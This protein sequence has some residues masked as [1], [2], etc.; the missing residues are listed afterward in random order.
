MRM[1]CA[2]DGSEYSQWAVQA[3][4]AFAS[5]EPESVTLLHVIDAP[6]IA[7]AQGTNLVSANRA[8]KASE[9][10]GRILLRETE[11]WARV[12]LSQAVTGPRTAF[13]SVLAHGPVARTLVRQARRLKTNL[14]VMGSQGLSDIP[15]VL[16]GSISGEVLATAPCPILVIKQP[17]K[18]LVRVALAVDPSNA[19]R[20]AARFL[21]TRLLPQSAT[22]TI[23][24]SAEPA[25]TEA[26]G[27]PSLRIATR[28]ADPPGTRTVNR[29]GR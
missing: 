13:Q 6:A 22:V 20:A 2:V 7:T 14:I 23:L 29:P 1:L 18:Q 16:M 15:G 27:A 28:G 12:A 4:E 26:C 11:R 17:I 19:S 25:V 10:A 3:L 5:R 21:S 8:L 24:C 9:K